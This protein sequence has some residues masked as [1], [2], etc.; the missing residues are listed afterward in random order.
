MSDWPAF[1]PSPS[2]PE[3]PAPPPFFPQQ[4]F[5]PFATYVLIGLCALVFLLMT[6]AGG[7]TNGQVLLDFGASYAPYF[8]S[9]Q[10]FRLVMPMFLHIGW[11]HLLVNM[12]ALYILGPLLERMYG[13]GRYSFLYIV[14][15]IGG[16]LLS[17]AH[18]NREIAAGASG[19]IFGVA[20]AIVLAGLVHREALPYP[21]A[22]VFRR[23]R[24]PLVLA[25]FIVL[26]L[27]FGYVVPGIDNWVHLGGLTTG[28]I[29]SLVIPPPKAD[30]LT[31]MAEEKPSQAI[32]VVPL[33]AVVLAFAGA[34]NH[35][36]V[37]IRVTQLLTQ[38]QRLRDDA[39]PDQAAEIY[40]QAERLA[41]GDDRAHEQ[42]ALLRAQQKQYPEAIAEY[43]QALRLNPDS[44]EAQLGLGVVYQQTGELARAQKLF[45]AVLGKNLATAEAQE[46]LGDAYFGQKVYDE[47]IGHYQAALRLSPNLAVAHNNLAWLY[48]T[49][50][51]PHFKDP[52]RAL[53]HA[54]RAVQLSAWKQAD[55][56]DTLA[57][58]L[59]AGGDY[60]QAV[61]VEERALALDPRNAELHDHMSRY[62]KAAGEY[63]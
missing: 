7:S 63:I 61:K 43:Q 28:C 44:P 17:M 52:A 4:R 16:T 9:G 20:G 59:Y 11:L 38:A 5:V 32:V 14:A 26:N 21:L 56:I 13:Y 31:G 6:A 10:Y 29:L 50:D 18:S 2:P 27:I 51:D 35:Y 47:A 53:V 58:S 3:P 46:A 19:A 23:G 33:L 54:Q 55:F 22:R 60:K 30:S 57:E 34:A 41:P 40:Q 1:N 42:F 36:R 48:A 45:E 49:S 12:Y 37:S 62:R 24:L 25:V 39:H 15:G 8:R